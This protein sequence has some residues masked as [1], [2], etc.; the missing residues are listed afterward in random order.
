M[1]GVAKESLN[2]KA[3]FK[4]K[5][6]D[7][8]KRGPQWTSLWHSDSVVYLGALG[9]APFAGAKKLFCLVVMLRKLFFL[10]MNLK[11]CRNSHVEHHLEHLKY[12]ENVGWPGLNSRPRWGSLLPL[13]ACRFPPRPTLLRPFGR[14]TAV[15]SGKC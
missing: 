9:E 1:S 13:A 3:R 14:K 7:S 5:V 4:L 12:Q 11:C 2:Y 8:F 6:L 10:K 15:R